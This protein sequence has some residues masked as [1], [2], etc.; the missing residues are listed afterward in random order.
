MY[1]FRFNSDLDDIRYEVDSELVSGLGDDIVRLIEAGKA[2]VAETPAPP[3]LEG[4]ATVRNTTLAARR[5]EAAIF[6]RYMD[7]NTRGTS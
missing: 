3:H 4:S 5:A 7:N 2:E 1:H 6:S